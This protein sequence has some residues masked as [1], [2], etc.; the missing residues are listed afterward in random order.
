MS[1]IADEVQGNA[2]LDAWLDK[3]LDELLP[4]KLEKIDAARTTRKLGKQMSF[5]EMST[6]STNWLTRTRKL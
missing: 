4:K 6:R 3:K 5:S 1:T 2:Q